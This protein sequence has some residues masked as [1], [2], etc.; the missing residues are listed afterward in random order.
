MGHNDGHFVGEQKGIIHKV[1][2]R[3]LKA[4]RKKKMVCIR[5]LLLHTENA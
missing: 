3:A 2:Y 4:R 5:L 1:S